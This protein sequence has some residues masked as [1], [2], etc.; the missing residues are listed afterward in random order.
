MKPAWLYL[1]S[2]IANVF[3][4]Q[5]IVGLTA[6]LS[7]R[8]YTEMLSPV[9]FG[10]TM[11]V[12]GVV[13]LFDSFS[14]MALNQTL[15]SRCGPHSESEK[16]RQI[17]IGL[18]WAYLKWAVPSGALL[19]LLGSAVMIGLG[20]QK[21][22]A[23]IPALIIL[24]IVA[25]TSKASLIN[26]IVIERRYGH[27]SAWIVG[28]GV[29]V[30][31]GTVSALHMWHAD[32]IGFLAGYV[33]S[34][35]ISTS[36]FIVALSPTHL[37]MVDLDQT[38]EEIRSALTYGI[39]VAFMGPLGWISTYLD[40]YILGGLLGVAATGVYVAVT[41]LVGRPYA[42][43][44]AVLSNYFRPF[45]FQSSLTHEGAQGCLRILFN[46]VRASLLIG[47]TGTL[48]VALLGDWIA[49]IMLAEAFREGAP[50][51]M[52]LFALSHTLSN[53]THAADNAILALRGS[54]QLLRVQII[55]S[56]GSLSLIPAGIILGGVV[57]GL[58]GRCL[59]EAVKLSVVMLLAI[60]M[61][62]RTDGM[63]G[64]LS[65]KTEVNST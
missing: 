53:T 13:A 2:R 27:Y 16:R 39:P 22:W 30:L 60:R 11:L 48:A 40:R 4:G 64:V 14:V 46:W 20:Y 44:T 55:L 36:F 29:F 63:L 50:L 49:N 3:W 51:L 57:G 24:Y 62:R 5:I 9:E 33:L 41:G 18:S 54:R 31:I 61:I 26:L 7:I 10:T 6:L 42:M 37:R 32:A 8:I 43:V 23:I 15:L 19:A 38:H 45:Y 58:I 12:L 65:G 1:Y 34:R 25:E 21:I 59:A 17:S 56:F 28:E 52:V 35:L 47:L